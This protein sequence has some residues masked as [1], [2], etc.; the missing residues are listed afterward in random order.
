MNFKEFTRRY[1]KEIKVGIIVFV[2]LMILQ[3]FKRLRN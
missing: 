1:N 2:G 3:L